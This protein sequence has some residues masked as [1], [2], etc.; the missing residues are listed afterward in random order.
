MYPLPLPGGSESGTIAG[1]Y[2]EGGSDGAAVGVGSGAAVG[3]G[4]GAVVSDG[5]ASG[6]SDG[7]WVVAEIGEG[8]AV[9]AGVL[10]SLG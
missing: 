8:T 9:G 1:T 7:S 4:S 5:L 2:A 6:K 3:V 10:G